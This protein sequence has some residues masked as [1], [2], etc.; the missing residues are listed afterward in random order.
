MGYSWV[1]Y[2][3]R[4][5]IP[6]ELHTMRVREHLMFVSALAQMSV[7]GL[8]QNLGISYLGIN[9]LNGREANHSFI[10]HDSDT[11]EHVSLEYD[12]EHPK[13][14]P[15][16]KLDHEP[17]VREV[18]CT[19][20]GLRIRAVVG[21]LEDLAARLV[22]GALIAGGNHWQCTGNLMRDQSIHREAISPAMVHEEWL[23]VGTKE[24]S[25]LAFFS[26]LRLRFRTNMLRQTSQTNRRELQTEQVPIS[27]SDDKGEAQAFSPTADK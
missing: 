25:P 1:W 24:V 19:S 6:T 27:W 22:V 21:S 16:V 8:A 7:S 14:V 20:D 3:H 15:M 9:Q 18:K 13:G 12:A 4:V 26:S 11:A 23:T 10:F 17:S 2:S 5:R